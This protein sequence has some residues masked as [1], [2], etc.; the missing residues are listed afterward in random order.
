MK[1]Y[2]YTYSTCAEY[3]RIYYYR[4]R[5][6]RLAQQK[7]YYK[8]NKEKLKLKRLLKKESSLQPL[9]IN[10]VPIKKQTKSQSERS[11]EYYQTHKK[12][13]KKYNKKYYRKNREKQLA[14]FKEYYKRKKE[15]K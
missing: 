14:Y 6:Q 13:K 3:H 4:H 1:K 10:D 5:E 11:K 12:Q 8:Q 15:K 2:P 9:P 7:K